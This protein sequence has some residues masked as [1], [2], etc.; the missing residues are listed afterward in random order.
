MCRDQNCVAATE[1]FWPKVPTFGCRGNMS[2]TCRRLSQPRYKSYGIVSFV[3]IPT[4]KKCY[5]GAIFEFCSFLEVLIT[6][7][8]SAS[9]PTSQH[10][11]TRQQKRNTLPTLQRLCPPLSPWVWQQRQGLM[12]PLLFMGLLVLF[13]RWLQFVSNCWHRKLKLKCASRKS[14]WDFWHTPKILVQ[15]VLLSRDSIL[16]FCLCSQRGCWNS[17]FHPH[18]FWVSVEEPKQ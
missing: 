4:Y 12:A 16:T 10:N 14:L 5:A 9:E 7:Q 11:N 15:S 6:L 13:H 17:E 3:L 8:Y 1:A 18:S 2:P